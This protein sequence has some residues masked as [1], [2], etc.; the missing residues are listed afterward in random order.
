[1]IKAAEFWVKEGN[2]FAA[3]ADSRQ[4]SHAGQWFHRGGT[5]FTGTH[6]SGA[7]GR[8]VPIRG[9]GSPGERITTFAFWTKCSFAA[10]AAT[11]LAGQAA[12]DSRLKT[13]GASQPFS[14]NQTGT[15][16]RGHL[17]QFVSAILQA[18]KTILIEME[19]IKRDRQAD[20]HQPP[21]ATSSASGVTSHSPK[22]SGD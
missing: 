3:A 1:V 5:G 18:G 4:A 9:G 6:S 11:L 15:L 10:R 20:N 16:S 14:L 22:N 2:I 7:S 12:A 17:A 19:G 21:L 13:A 8:T